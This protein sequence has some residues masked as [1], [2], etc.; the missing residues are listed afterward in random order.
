MKRDI[1][2]T[3][4]P[5]VGSVARDH[6]AN[7]RTYL[8]WLRT[9]MSVAAIGVAVA[10]FAPDRGGNAVASGLILIVAGL[11]V[12]GYGTFRYRNVG[13]QIEAG[14]F[15]PAAFG[16]IGTASVVMVLAAVAVVIL[17]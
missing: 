2:G 12:S 8:A 9:G 11:L 6:L 16:A 3:T 17:I 13:R 10:K 1:H 5:N 15:A 7:E 4:Q 14:V